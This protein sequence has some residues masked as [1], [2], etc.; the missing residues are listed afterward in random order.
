MGLHGQLMVLIVL[1]YLGPR[2]AKEELR[3]PTPVIRGLGTAPDN[4][5][6]G[7]LL[8]RLDTRLTYRTVR[9]LV[10]IREHPGTSNREVAQGAEVPDEGQASKLLGRL[11]KLGLLVNSRPHGPGFTNRWRL[12]ARGEQVLSSVNRY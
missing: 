2:A 4:E 10:F 1:P 5:D 3:R 11:E 8:E 6:T 7:R 9:C 12:T